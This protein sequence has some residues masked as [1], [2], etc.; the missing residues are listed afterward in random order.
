MRSLSPGPFTEHFGSAAPYLA[1]A[2]INYSRL[3]Q[4]TWYSRSLL[5]SAER[6]KLQ[7]GTRRAVFFQ[8]REQ[9]TW[10][11]AQR[12]SGTLRGRLQAEDRQI[13]CDQSRAKGRT[14]EG[15]RGWGGVGI[16]PHYLS[17]LRDYPGARIS[18]TLFRARGNKLAGS[19]GSAASRGSARSQR[20]SCREYENKGIQEYTRGSDRS[21]G[22]L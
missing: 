7:K 21:S 13:Q 17:F 1:S 19:A 20:S 5:D 2:S 6:C 15:G 8:S 11:E 3:M 9:K 14:A 10:I 12:V 4:F 22:L 16:R 18:R